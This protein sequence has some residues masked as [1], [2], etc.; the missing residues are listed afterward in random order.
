MT[1]LTA[2]FL[3]RPEVILLDE[4]TNSLD[5]ASARQL[6]QALD[7]HQGAVIV[8]SHDV[9]FLHSCGITR[10]LRLDRAGRL[11]AIDPL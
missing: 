9:P 7:C 8:A 2:L 6:A 10:W 4:P 1:A 5:M 11:T 3:R